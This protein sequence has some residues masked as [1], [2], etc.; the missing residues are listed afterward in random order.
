ME[1]ILQG[2]PQLTQADVL[3][4]LDYARRLAESHSVVR[5]AS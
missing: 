5:L 3:A 2:Y 1:D 4:C